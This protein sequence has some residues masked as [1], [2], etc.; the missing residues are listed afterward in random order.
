[1]YGVLKYFGSAPYNFDETQDLSYFITIEKDNG[2]IAT[3]WSLGLEKA[4]SSSKEAINVGDRVN[5]KFTGKEPIRLSNGKW[6]HKSSFEIHKSEKVLPESRN[7]AK[8]KIS[9]SNP[10]RKISNHAH[11]SS[12]ELTIID[13]FTFALVGSL[14]GFIILG[15][16]LAS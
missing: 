3:M 12:R 2:E 7:N 14:F 1:M 5:I 8:T 15:A 10:T 16:L 4:M 13:K 6:A 11:K 9:T